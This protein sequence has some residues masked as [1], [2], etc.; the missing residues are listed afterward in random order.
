MFLASYRGWFWG[1]G[2]LAAAVG[3]SVAFVAESRRQPPS[4]GTSFGLACGFAALALMLVL[5]WYGVRKRQYRSRLGTLAGWLQAHV[6]LGLL[7]PVVVLLHAGFQFRDRLAT[8]AFVCLLLVV[9]SGVV[10]MVC[11]ALLPRLLTDVESNL[12]AEQAAA[13]LNRLASSMAALAAGRSAIFQRLY[14]R[15]VEES[16]PRPLAG[17]RILFQRVSRRSVQ[18][19]RDTPWA[20][21][22]KRVPEAEREALNRL[23]ELSRQHKE[24][25]LGLIAQ[26]RYRNLLDVWL[27]V[28]LPLCAALVLLVAAHLVAVWAYAW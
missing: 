27:Y 7:V 17:W 1:L 26:Q 6:Y 4:G 19:E 9:A 12:T 25:H 10:G 15:L 18:Q 13:E 28:H 11:Y 14:Q 3:L 8:A 2:S 21:L 5:L 22:L 23:L 20:P 16:R 24:L